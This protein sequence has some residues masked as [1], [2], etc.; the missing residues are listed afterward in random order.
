MFELHKEFQRNDMLVEG[1]K[2]FVLGYYNL[3]RSGY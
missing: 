1:H 2:D 3:Q